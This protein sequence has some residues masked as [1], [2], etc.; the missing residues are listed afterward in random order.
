[1]S[2]ERSNLVTMKCPIFSVSDKI[3]YPNDI[4]YVLNNYMSNLPTITTNKK[5]SY[6]NVSCAFDIE[7]T[8]FYV[9]GEKR[10][11]MY[12]WTLG[13]NGAVIVGRTWLELLEVYKS[14]TEYLHTYTDRRLVI[15]VHNLG[16]EFQFMRKRLEWLNVFSIEQ[17]KPIY[18]V[19]SEGVEFRC[20]YLLSGYSLARL[21]TQLRK[22]KVEKAVGDLDYSL[23]RGNKT[24]LT[25]KELEYCVKD[26]KV[27]MNYIQERIEIEGD[28]T[29]I[30]LTKTGYVRTYCRNA[31]MYEGKSHKRNGW[32]FVEYTRFMSSLRLEVD[33]Y[34]QLKRAFQGGF[35]HA[36]A[37][38]SGQTLTNVSSFDFTSSY[39]AVMI[40]ERF[41]MSS[42]QRVV[43]K[44]N[45]EFRKNLKCYCCL[46]DV[47]IYD[48]ES[49]TIFEHPLSLSRCFNVKGV[50]EDNG[51]VVTA[52]KITTTV[53]EQD[54]YILE[55]FYKWSKMRVG[56]FKRYKKGYLPTNFVKAILKLYSD[57]TTLKGV[58]GREYEYLL[59]KEMINSCYGM[60]VTDIC[61]DEIIYNNGEWFDKSVDIA[62][63]LNKYNRSV[64][65]FLFYPWGVWITAYARR[66]LFSGIYAFKHDYIYSDTDSLKV[67]NFDKH[68]D[69]IN[70]YNTMILEKLKTAMKY[71]GLPFD[72][73]QPKTIEGVSK[74]LGVWDFEGTYT[75]FKTLGAKRYITE[76]INK[77]GEKDISIT[78]SGVNKHTA[79][80]YLINKFGDGIFEAFKDDLYIPRVNDLNQDLYTDDGVKIDN[81]CGKN[82]H[83]YLDD[84][85]CG[86]LTDYLGNKC[87]Y[88]ELSSTHLESTD[89]TLSLS[90]TYLNYLMGIREYNK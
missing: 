78:V 62:D 22:Y 14:L 51:R 61:R 2:K 24:P 64:K 25:D 9:N 45:E 28:I 37:F 59:S 82:T 27:V 32:K 8:S 1:M 70:N 42:A 16:F 5:I 21:G 75:R 72:L 29:K 30:P 3:Y 87:E 47:E 12:E 73:I 41:P 69:Y 20:S 57:K 33:E 67:L 77:K 17:R 88:E 71:H 83:T 60:A 23:L 84:Y 80:P 19:T 74:P 49:T 4:N 65:R 44:S 85:Q 35:T 52:E 66:N 6:Y 31:C 89:Y 48:L 10:A 90:D 53:T 58:S 38:Y 18:A 7:T 36:N 86:I 55:K 46:F 40:S 13:L 54:F 56:N 76:K 79:V 50:S 68:M 43:I 34:K 15:Y 11:I 63:S 81:P 26:V 39:P